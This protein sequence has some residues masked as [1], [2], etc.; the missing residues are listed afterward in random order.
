[1]KNRRSKFGWGARLL[2]LCVLAALPLGCATTGGGVPVPDSA[3]L[4]RA[5]Q[6]WPGTTLEDLNHGRTAYVQNCAACHD[7]HE[8]SEFSP[9][10]WK[11]IMVKMSRKAHLNDAASDSILHYLSAATGKEN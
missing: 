10:E 7:L 2:G 3:A 8:A 4:S 6:E 1:M 11:R 9:S 5:A